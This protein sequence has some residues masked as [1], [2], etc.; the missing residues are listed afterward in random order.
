MRSLENEL[1]KQA[2]DDEYSEMLHMPVSGIDANTRAGSDGDPR[3]SIEWLDN[4]LRDA[5]AAL[6][7]GRLSAITLIP[8]NGIAYRLVRRDLIRFWSTPWSRRETP[9]AI[10]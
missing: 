10:Q 1:L 6:L 4:F 8:C 2:G 9:A 5:Q 7:K 3:Q